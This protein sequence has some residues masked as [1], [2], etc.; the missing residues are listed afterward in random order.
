MHI[1]DNCS[2]SHLNSL[3]SICKINVEFQFYTWLQKTETD[4]VFKCFMNF[5]PPNW[6]HHRSEYILVYK[7]SWWISSKLSHYI[8][9]SSLPPTFP[10]VSYSSTF[11]PPQQINVPLSSSLPLHPL[12][13]CCI[14]NFQLAHS[15]TNPLLSQMLFFAWIW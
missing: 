4:C 13:L 10:H 8:I 2:N 7:S 3:L 1:N 5:N 14:N 6:Q 11:C 9:F 15:L 12:S